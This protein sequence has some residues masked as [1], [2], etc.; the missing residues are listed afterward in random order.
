MP[1]LDRVAQGGG[2]AGVDA[3]DL[4]QVHA[5]MAGEPKDQGGDHDQRREEG[6]QQ[7]EHGLTLGHG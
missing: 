2:R 4:L 1:L 6:S 5:L 3:A 7:S